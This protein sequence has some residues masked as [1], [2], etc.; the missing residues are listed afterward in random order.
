MGSSFR[1]KEIKITFSEGKSPISGI[2]ENEILYPR[3]SYLEC[4]IIF[5]AI[6]SKKRLKLKVNQLP[7]TL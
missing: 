5:S 7:Q 3:L 6:F 2:F 1:I 4:L